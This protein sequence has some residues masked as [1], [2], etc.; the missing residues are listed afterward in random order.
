MDRSLIFPQ[1]YTN[2]KCALQDTACEQNKNSQVIYC[3]EH[4]AILQDGLVT[5]QPPTFTN[6]VMTQN[7]TLTNF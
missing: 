3:P 5:Q 7:A 1:S 2:A 6:Y 4:L